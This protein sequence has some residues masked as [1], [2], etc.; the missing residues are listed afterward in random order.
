MAHLLPEHVVLGAMIQRSSIEEDAEVAKPVPQVVQEE[1]VDRPV[2]GRDGRGGFECIT[3]KNVDQVV[4]VAS[5]E[6]MPERTA[7][8][9]VVSPG[10]SLRLGEGAGSHVR[11]VRLIV[12]L[13]VFQTMEWPVPLEVLHKLK[14]SVNTVKQGRRTVKNSRL[15]W[16]KLVSPNHPWSQPSS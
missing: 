1:I 2:P 10:H 8:Q 11:Q 3:E 6:R 15:S 5:Q 7:E 16:R 12:D 14:W 13:S 4:R 9:E